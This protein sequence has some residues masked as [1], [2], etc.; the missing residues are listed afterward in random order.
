MP[1]CAQPYIYLRQLVEP[2]EELVEGG[3]QVVRGQGL[4]QRGE[5]HDVGVQDT[6]VVVA[7]E[8][9]V[10]MIKHNVVK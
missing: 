5:V 3:H 9:R 7:L 4:R 1:S 2:S 6:Y 8:Y 10:G